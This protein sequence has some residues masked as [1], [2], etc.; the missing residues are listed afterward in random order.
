MITKQRVQNYFTDLFLFFCGFIV[1][2]SAGYRIPGLG[3]GNEYF[4]SG[5]GLANQYFRNPFDVHEMIQ[6][7][8]EKE[9]IREE[10]VLADI[11]RRRAL[12]AEVRRE[13]MIDGELLALRARGG[14]GG[15]G[16]DNAFD[17]FTS[18]PMGGGMM[19]FEPKEVPF[20]QNEGLSLEERIAMSLEK[21]LGMGV[22]RETGGLEMVPFQRVS[23]EPKIKEGTPSSSEVHKKKEKIVITVSMF[24]SVSY[25]WIY[26]IGKNVFICI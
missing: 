20:Q 6:T 16:R 2:I 24:S 18:F 19:G 25:T 9:R 10:I 12:L 14:G 23:A 3:R 13:M 5:F 8:I 15:Q 21:R 7:E 1:G 26:V 11:A 17:G 22:R 4:N